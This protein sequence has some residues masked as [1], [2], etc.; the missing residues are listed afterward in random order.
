MIN[1][2]L[3]MH[4]WL[5]RMRLS[6]ALLNVLQSTRHG[7]V[8]CF[9]KFECV[10]E[11]DIYQLQCPVIYACLPASGEWLW[12]WYVYMHNVCND[13]A[14]M[15]ML[16]DILCVCINQPPTTTAPT[17]F[18]TANT[19]NTTTQPPNKNALAHPTHT[20]T[21]PSYPHSR[22][23]ITHAVCL[24][25]ARACDVLSMRWWCVCVWW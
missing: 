9:C 7:C 14:C 13:Y 8:V 17:P 24:W 3:I 18:T 6:F 16:C 10:N 25:C 5:W 11:S 12:M 22:S 15:I 2:C 20:H 21:P 23:C 19:A 4:A 1:V